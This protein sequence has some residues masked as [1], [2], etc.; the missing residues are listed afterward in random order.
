MVVDRS[1]LAANLRT[2]YDFEGKS[3]ICVGAGGGLLLEPAS[4]VASVVAIDRDAEA[5]GRFRTEART[6]WAGIPIRFVPRDF[7]SVNLQGDVV[8]FEFCMHMMKDPRGAL[9][10]ARSLASDIVIMEHLPGSKWVYY[11]AGEDEVLRCT[12]TFESFGVRRQKRFTAE[13]RFNDWNA[14]A[15]RLS[16][17]GKESRRRVLE[18]KEAKEVHM[19]MDYGLYLL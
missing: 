10:H 6:K 17:L 8:Y 16:G 14:F 5:L 2:F 7:E 1:E 11:W 12:R 18:L 13:Q 15:E 3:T 4:G 19:P 9:E